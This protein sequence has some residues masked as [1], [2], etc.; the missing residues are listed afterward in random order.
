MPGNRKPQKH[1]PGGARSGKGLK[2]TDVHRKQNM[3]ITQRKERL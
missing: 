2:S 3:S 1:P